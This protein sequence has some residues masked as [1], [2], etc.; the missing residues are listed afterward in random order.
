MKKKTLYHIYTALTVILFIYLFGCTGKDDQKS[1]VVAQV[2]AAQI[3]N[4]ELE[5]SIPEGTSNEVRNALKRNLMEKWIEE[6][7]FYQVALEEGLRLSD[8]EARQV[9][10]YRKSLLINKFLENR[11]SHD[12]RILEQE[13]EDYYQ[14][15]I[16]EFIWGDD[17]VHLIHLILENDDSAI[18]QEI[19][20]SKDLLDVIKK[21]YF[22][23]QSTNE[24]PIGDLGYQKVD[25]FPTPII[26]ALRNLKTGQIRG[27]I[28][29]N[30]GYHYIQLLDYQKKG[31]TKSL[32]V[33]RDE[34][35]MRLFLMKR[36][37][38]IE[39]LKRTLRARF[40]IQT[41]LSKLSE[42]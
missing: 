30:H 29:T 2:D 26:R 37:E 24:R 28:R 33:V 34:V 38:E 16:G 22:D 39:N 10:N 41:D 35:Y 8:D 25:E 36:D 5:S 6:E 15:Q 40:T 3:T 17:Y 19:R 42:P 20:K 27:P 14:K 18:K 9:E 13:I 11:L 31:S 32:D 4:E 7:I 21:N 1:N 12:Y 23:Q